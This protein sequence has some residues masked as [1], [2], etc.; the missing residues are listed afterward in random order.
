MLKGIVRPLI[1]EAKRV[2]FDLTNVIYL[3]SSG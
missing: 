2:V 1:S 3:D